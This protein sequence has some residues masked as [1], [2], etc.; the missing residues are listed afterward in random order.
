MSVFDI[1]TN[2]Q[3]DKEEDGRKNGSLRAVK[4]IVLLLIKFEMLGEKKRIKSGVGER[5]KRNRSKEKI[6]RGTTGA[7]SKVNLDC[8]LQSGTL[9]Y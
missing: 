1:V 7:C 6:G 4:R 9:G 2:Q 8:Q 3:R 5:E